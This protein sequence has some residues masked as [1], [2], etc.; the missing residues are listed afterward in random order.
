MQDQRR[1]SLPRFPPRSGR[2]HVLRPAGGALPDGGW[3]TGARATRPIRLMVEVDGPRLPVR[4]WG[5]DVPTPPPPPN[6]GSHA[7]VAGDGGEVNPA[8]MQGTILKVLVER[9]QAVQV[10]E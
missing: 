2:D 7:A 4:V 1:G 9:G 3:V 6:S 8:P 5:K 10:G